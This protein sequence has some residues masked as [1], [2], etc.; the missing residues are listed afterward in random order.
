MSPHHHLIKRELSLFVL[1][2]F[3][4]KLAN[5]MEA[6]H[7][8][9]SKISRF[10][11]I[12]QHLG[13]PLIVTEQY[14]KGI[15]QTTEDLITVLEN[16]GLYQ[17]LE[18]IRFS[19]FGESNFENA[20]KEHKKRRQLILTGIETHV[21]VLQTAFDAL[22]QGYEVFIVSDAITSRSP[23]DYDRALYRMQMAGCSIVTFEMVVFEWLRQA[24]TPEFKTVHK[25]VT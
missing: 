24:G 5:V 23:I 3:Q 11:E 10:I 6:K 14:P 9:E 12:T 16:Y 25:Y 2:D 21:C 22:E 17:P 4:E 20:L 8:V 1:I 7:D 13:V 18:K 15:G 19:C